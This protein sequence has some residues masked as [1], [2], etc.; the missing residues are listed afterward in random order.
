MTTVLSGHNPEP[1]IVAVDHIDDAVMRLTLR[2]QGETTTRDEPFFPFFYLA[3][4][5]LL[6]GFTQK[7]WI[8]KAEGAHRFAF[9]C[10]FES[11]NAVWEALRYM[12]DAFNH[13]VPTGVDSYT[14]LDALHFIPDPVTQ[15]LL[16][17]GRTLF[18]EMAFEDLH[19][20][21]LDIETYTTGT[22]GFSSAARA[23]VADSSCA[24]ASSHRLAVADQ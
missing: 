14:K 21:Q 3:D 9:L 1:H 13:R 24:N 19:R 15:Y 7:H 17:S 6:E 12:I 23:G 10:I 4:P 16:Q 18:K 5:S 22:H 8:K 20:L 2:S 11:W